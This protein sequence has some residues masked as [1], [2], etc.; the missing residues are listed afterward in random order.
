M[1]ELDR[2]AGEVI[3]K[4][5]ESRWIEAESHCRRLL[6]DH[7]G[8]LDLMQ[9][10]AV[11]L[12]QQG[13]L[14]EAEDLL[15][16]VA[17][18]RP[19][20]SAV[21]VNLGETRRQRGRLL[22]A[23]EA[24]R[25]AVTLDPHFVEAH[26]NLGVLLKEVGRDEEAA[27]SYRRALERNPNHDKAHYNLGN[28]LVEQGRVAAAV[29]EYERALA[30][31]PDW[32]E[33]RLNCG[34]ALVSLGEW[35]RAIVELEHARRLRPEDPDI[36]E[37]LGNVWSR[38]GELERARPFFSSAFAKRPERW[39]HRMHSELVVE[40]I[41][42]CNETIDVFRDH[43]RGVLD[44]CRDSDDAVT[45]K[46]LHTTAAEPPMLLAYH[47]RDDRELYESFAAFF[48]SK[49]RADE[50]LLRGGK[51]HVGIVVTSGHEGVFARCLGALIERLDREKLRVTM[52]TSLSGMNVLQSVFF[53]TPQEY[54]IIPSRLDEAVTRI[55][56]AAFDVLHYWEVGTDSTNYFLPF[57]RP[58]R[59]QST[60]WGW[61]VTTGNP[62]LDYYVSTVGIEPAD[63]QNHYREKLFCLPGNA[64]YYDRPPVPTARAT[65]ERFGVRD[66]DRVYFCPQNVRKYHPDFRRILGEL[67]KR[68]PAGRLLTIGDVDPAITGRFE[69]VMRRD[70]GESADRFIVI[71]RLA[72]EEYLAVLQ[73]ADVN[74][75]TWYY[76]GGAN[77]VYDSLAV[78][79]PMVTFPWT[80]H[81]G[82][83]AAATWRAI[84]IQELVATSGD[85]Y[86]E[87]ARGIAADQDQR[88]EISRRMI[89]RSGEILQDEAAVRAYEDFFLSAAEQ[90]K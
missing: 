73:S 24:L 23:E 56:E 50:P 74:L 82:R 58:A 75:D 59:V 46:D 57:F 15:A 39:L 81:R 67:L 17:E 18:N 85:D 84:D 48:G 12:A 7:P 16:V 40:P 53:K 41:M 9:L 77:T 44:R 31:R 78:G 33:A 21:W 37:T 19:Q 8:H 47:G 4:I 13:Q 70:L 2:Q 22:A 35:D 25:R 62:R 3:R 83:F 27:A 38:R 80:H 34:H 51:P 32:F 5:G 10:L 49:I 26:Y 45:V 52:V 65:L 79:T 29:E 28:V 42:D 90:R 63:G 6:A 54:L 68:D 61:P 71:P 14:E 1:S 76:G 86:I 36:A 30:L 11:I 60:T 55:R 72:R 66:G 87:R 69:S 64:T 20:Q 43:V 89:E 88:D